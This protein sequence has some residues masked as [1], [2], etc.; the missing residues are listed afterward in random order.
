MPPFIVRPKEK[1]EDLNDYSECNST[2]WHPELT[3]LNL[4]VNLLKTETISIKGHEYYSAQ[5]SYHP[6]DLTYQSFCKTH[7]SYGNNALSSIAETN[8]RGLD[9]FNRISCCLVPP[10]DVPIARFCGA[11]SS[12]SVLERL[13]LFVNMWL[14][15]RFRWPICYLCCHLLRD[16][17]L[18]GCS[19]LNMLRKRKSVLCEIFSH[20]S[21]DEVYS[22]I[23]LCPYWKVG[24]RVLTDF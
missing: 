23:I 20:V 8:S 24:C 7:V 12:H 1:S 22:G 4:V 5:S 19:V 6:H 18:P 9:A 11:M 3:V 21:H 14:D 10:Y 16:H 13:L 15:L 2:P 17:V